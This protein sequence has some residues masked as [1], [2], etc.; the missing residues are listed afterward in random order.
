MKKLSA[1]VLVAQLGW[2]SMSLAAPAQTSSNRC[3]NAV[4]SAKT[5]LSGERNMPV[6]IEVENISRRYRNPPSSRGLVFQVEGARGENIMN[7][8]RMLLGISQT[9]LGKCPDLGTVTFYLSQSDWLKVYGAVNGRVKEFACLMPTD[10]YRPAW[11][12]RFCA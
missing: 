2:L 11:G 12:Q 8:P 10:R 6:Q 1:I 9:V 3:A 7:S 5:R 4:R